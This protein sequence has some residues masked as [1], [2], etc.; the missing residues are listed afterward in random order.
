[1][2]NRTSRG[3]SDPA[4]LTGPYAGARCGVQ[5][6]SQVTIQFFCFVSVLGLVQQSKGKM[7]SRGKTAQSATRGGAGGGE[8]PGAY[9]SPANQ[10]GL[11]LDVHVDPPTDSHH[12][13]HV[14]VRQRSWGR[15]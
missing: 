10:L 5:N 8:P 1:M 6:T 12:G 3:H 14:Q 15:I 7:A 13:R 9:E 4:P 2:C 11:Q